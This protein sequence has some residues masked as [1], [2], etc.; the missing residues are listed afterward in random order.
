M[1]G[2]GVKPS[3]YGWVRDF[4]TDR[5]QRVMKNN[6]KSNWLQCTSVVPQGNILGPILFL[7][8]LNDLPDCIQ[9]S[10]FFYMQ[11]MPKYLSV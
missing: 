8:Y 7:I 1:H 6:C 2:Y 9:Y 4:S 10:E 3:V 5:Q 11:T